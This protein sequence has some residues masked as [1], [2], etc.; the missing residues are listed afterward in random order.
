MKIGIFGSGVIVTVALKAME[1]MDDVSCEA[2]WCRECDIVDAK[3]LQEE[4]QIP[5]L[6]TDTEAFLEDES[7]DTVYVGLVNSAHYEYTRKA[8]EAGKN[9]ICEKPFTATGRQA[10]KLIEIAKN[11]GL[12]LFEAI[13]SRYMDNYDEIAR[14]LEKIG[15]VTLIQANYSQ[16]SRRFGSYLEGQVLPA[17]DP[18]L[19]GGSLYDINLYCIQ[20]IM[21]LFGRPKSVN[22]MANIGFNGIDTSGALLMDY[23]DFKAVA[24]GAKD[25]DSP[26]RWVI[27]GQKGYI[28]VQS[29]STKVE[30]VVLQIRGE[31]PVCIDVSPVGNAMVNEF[32][33]ID[34]IMKRG[35]YDLCYAY[36]QKTQDVMDVMEMA[37]KEA[38]IHFDADDE[39][40]E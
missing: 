25:S 11:K 3:K 7:F 34:E 37:R 33:K 36:M 15:K 4:Y 27:Q 1:S 40:I 35:D 32:H 14:Q 18:T 19:A 17:F 9:V 10:K 13:M 29:G 39:V 20:F 6:Y 12:F 38:G 26:I 24:I 8:L 16:Y 22:Y 28:E 23:G 5:N 21:G 2:M 30:N 31:D